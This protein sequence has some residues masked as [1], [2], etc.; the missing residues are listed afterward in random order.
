MAVGRCSSLSKKMQLGVVGQRRKRKMVA[1]ATRKS[2]SREEGAGSGEWLA[3]MIEEE[4][5]AAA[6]KVG[7]GDCSRGGGLRPRG[8]EGEDADAATTVVEEEV[9]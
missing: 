8:E 5:K 6:G 4:S 2:R 1:M 7:A 3:A 9:R